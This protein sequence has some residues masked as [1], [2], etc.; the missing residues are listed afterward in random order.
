MLLWFLQ[1]M[2]TIMWITR[3]ATLLNTSLALQW[4][5]GAL[6][7]LA[8]LDN[9]NSQQKVDLV[10][11]AVASCCCLDL[12]CKVIEHSQPPVKCKAQGTPVM[13]AMLVRMCACHATSGKY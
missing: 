11:V 13:M 4:R 1:G 5:L 8:S 2:L 9:S 10:Q 6:N 3:L 7:Y 12:P